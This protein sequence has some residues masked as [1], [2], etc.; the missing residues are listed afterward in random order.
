MD[1]EVGLC[2]G[3]DMQTSEAKR[4][5]VK[6]KATAKNTVE[7]GKKKAAKGKPKQEKKES[8]GEDKQKKKENVPEKSLIM[9]NTSIEVRR[10][11]IAR[12]NELQHKDGV[13]KKMVG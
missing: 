13:Q 8:K 1:E 9:A 12:Q 10:Q 11:L 6:T 5:V 2:D 7:E 3:G 4:L